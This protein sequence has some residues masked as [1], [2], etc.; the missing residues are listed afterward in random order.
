MKDERAQGL[1]AKVSANGGWLWLM[2]VGVVALAASQGFRFEYLLSAALLA[3]LLAIG[4]RAR[5]LAICALPFAAA[6]LIYDNMTPLLVFRGEIHVADLHAAELALFGIAGESGPILPS[7]F[8]ASRTHW[9]LDLA[10]GFSYLFYLYWVFLV[11]VV[12]FLRGDERASARLG[13]SFLLVNLVGIV[14][15]LVYPAAPPWYVT[16]HGLGPAV[17][18]ALPSAAGAAR[19]DELLGITYFEGFYARSRNVFGAMPSLHVAYPVVVFLVV[20]RRSWAWAITSL[21]F[22][23][24]VALAAVYLEHHYVLDVMGGVVAAVASTA[25]V[26]AW[27][28]YVGSRERGDDRRDDEPEAPREAAR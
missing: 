7:T 6:G 9:L 2:P 19:F 5:R 26:F 11:A 28:R 12:L 14:V 16:E 4:P 21:A 18:D 8:L 24:L 1:F 17:M 10:C 15:W 22:A 27:Y 20:W 23:L 3:G 25:A 13:W